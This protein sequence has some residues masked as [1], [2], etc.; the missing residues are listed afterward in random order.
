M[1]ITV[2]SVKNKHQLAKHISSQSDF[3][4]IGVVYGTKAEVN[5]FV[6]S[7]VQPQNRTLGVVLISLR[8]TPN[9]TG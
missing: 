9:V 1:A 2:S 5:Q 3:D 7:Q 4:V 8:V 6:S